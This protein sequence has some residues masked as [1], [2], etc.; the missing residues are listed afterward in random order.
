M[1]TMAMRCS[2]AQVR[3]LRRTRRVRGLPCRAKA[4]SCGVATRQGTSR[5][6]NEDRCDAN[7]QESLVGNAKPWFLAVYDGHGG[8]ACA[9]WLEANLKNAVEYY[10]DPDSPEK[11]LTKAFLEA[12]KVLLAP[13]K[14]FMGQFG[15][16]GVGGSK[17]GSTA[18]IALVYQDKGSKKK[19]IAVANVGDARVLLIRSG[20][21]VE[22]L[23]V[24]H[25]PDNEDERKRIEK[26][27]PNPELPLVRF[28]GSTWR[29]GGILALSRAFGDAYMKSTGQFEGIS[30]MNNDYSSGFGV[31]AEPEVQVVELGEDEEAYLVLSSDGLFANRERGG[32]GGFENEEVGAFLAKSKSR[33]LDEIAGYLT[34]QAQ[35]RGS[36]DDVTVVVAKL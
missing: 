34:T 8:S 33:G 4:G 7:P 16:R 21:Q 23:T 5:R 24:D 3:F 20:G 19:K 10:W 26:K 17:C 27:N 18:A 32:G 36:T 6:V 30:S 22:Q 25:V 28:V 12:D 31:I 15:E 29:V 14:G 2:C 1:A 35:E 11:T 9:S 13:K